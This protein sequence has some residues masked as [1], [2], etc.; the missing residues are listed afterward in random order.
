MTDREFK[1]RVYR[2]LLEQ[3]QP[4]VPEQAQR[5]KKLM[6]EVNKKIAEERD[7]IALD[8]AEVEKMSNAGTN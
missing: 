7:E 5:H 4:L 3:H 2:L 1:L 6:N 8:N